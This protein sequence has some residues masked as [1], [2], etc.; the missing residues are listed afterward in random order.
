MIKV[1]KLSIMVF[2]VALSMTAPAQ[3]PTPFSQM[4]PLNRGLIAIHKE[5][6]ENFISWRLLGTDPQDITF[7]LLRDGNVIASGLSVNNY[8]DSRGTSTS[9]YQVVTGEE[10]TPEVTPWLNLYKELKLQRP[11]NG[12]NKGG[13]P[14]GYMPQECEPADLDGDGEYELVVKWLPTDQRDPSQS[15]YSSPCLLDAYRLDGKFLWRIDL[16]QNI[17]SGSHYTQFLVY[18]FNGDGR[19]ELICKTA[20]GSKDGR[21]VFVTDAADEAAILNANN[22]TDYRN[23]NGYVLN[24]PEYLT[25]FDG[26]SG[27]ALHTIWYNPNRGFTT[28]ESV[29]YNA[30]WGDDYGNRGDRF[31]ACV[32]YLGGTAQNP[33]AVMCR[34]MYT[35]SYLW[36]VDFDGAKLS[37]RWLHA[38]ISPTIVEITN[39]SG[40]KTTKTYSTN[41]SG[42][43]STYTAY[44]QGGHNLAV[45]DV[46]GDGCDEIMYGAAAID[47]D[48]QLLYSTGLGHGDALH[49][50]DLAPDRPGLE[51]FMVQ[52][53]PPYGHHLRDAATGEL[54]IHQIGNGDTGR[55]LAADIDLSHRGYE[56]WTSDTYNVY[57]IQGNIL[58]SVESARPTIS[59]RVYWDGS[60]LDNLLDKT[61]IYTKNRRI[62]SLGNYGNSTQWGSKGYPCLSADLFG[63][64]REEIVL[65]N[66]ADSATLNIF[67]TTE[68]TKLRAPT[69]MHD[70]TYRMA[71]AWQAVGYNQPPHLGYFLPDSVGGRFVYETPDLRSQVVDLGQPIQRVLCRVKN[72]TGVAASRTLL[73][74]KVIKYIGVTEEF[75]FE[76]D[77]DG[78]GFCLSG[79]PQEKGIYE[80]VV[81]MQGNVMDVDLSDTIR[82]V[83][84]ES[85]GIRDM[86]HHSINSIPLVYDFQ[87]RRRHHAQEKGVYIVNGRKRLLYR[88]R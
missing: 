29:R 59:H 7:S 84:D 73:N 78:M 18:D 71:I 45:G 42:T 43:G 58:S 67:S 66:K 40:Q 86:E 12:I 61:N 60:G 19:S 26:M 14:Y 16:G 17:R 75:T 6:G 2:A 56:F 49:L 81:K 69:L 72:C 30:Q 44:A 79:T 48:G 8:T 68:P 80:I 4:E 76:K 64:W 31:L 47:N 62:V 32:A 33:S 15:G 63:D 50:G 39:S 55:G 23:S 70:H 22:R 85:S 38:S 20:P 77:A 9:T 57:D 13:E 37:T 54:L 46:D 3:I 1:A 41:T 10:V 82:I 28:G 52:E 5:N 11:A 35:R 74:G 27:E 34:G 24:G 21:G 83:V 65:F 53:E 87:G 51:F 25:V 88:G 36:A